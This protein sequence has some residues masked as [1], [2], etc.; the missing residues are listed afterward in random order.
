MATRNNGARKLAKY[1]A[2]IGDRLGDAAHMNRTVDAATVR[3][4]RQRKGEIPRAS[5]RTMRAM[6]QRSSPDRDTTTARG[7]TQVI[8]KTPGAYWQFDRLP[9][10]DTSEIALAVG[11]ATFKKA[12]RTAGVKRS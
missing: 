7:L 9:R 2:A 8:V 6:T 3:Q 5:G 1:A 4:Y 12:A 11:E 10:V